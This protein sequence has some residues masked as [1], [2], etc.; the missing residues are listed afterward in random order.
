MSDPQA[1]ISP[2]KPGNA[3]NWKGFVAGSGA[4][5]VSGAVT[6]PVDLVKVRMQLSG[7]GASVP[8]F[9]PRI[10]NAN[11]SPSMLRAAETVVRTEGARALYKG[12]SASLLRQA[13]FIGTK[14]G[15]YDV[16]KGYCQT[17]SE[18]GA[19]GNLGF[20][21]KILCG[22]GAGAMGA[23]VGNPSDLVMV[24]MQADGRLPIEQRRNYKN[25]G[26]AMVRIVRHEGVGTL[27]R[28][29]GPTVQRA[30]IITASQLAIYD[31]VKEEFVSSG[32]FQDGPQLHVASS[33]V[34]A[35]V[36]S[37][38]SNPVDLL[39]TRLMNMRP[40]STG[41]LPY[42]GL[43]DCL[44]QTVKNEGVLALWKGLGPTLARQAP[45][46]IVRFMCV[47]QIKKVLDALTAVPDPSNA[48]ASPALL[49]KTVGVAST[50]SHQ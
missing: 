15:T 3:E 9:N 12:L 50:S 49:L 37:V 17:S 21:S 27:W 16:L 39:K 20:F 44:V 36:A 45:L 40:D 4:A 48:C 7:T 6:H 42:T 23:A 2:V 43:Y 47:E 22:F 8:G 1:R 46:N 14:F 38:T 5:I 13:T 18:S 34:A 24:R 11:Y 31:Q 32:L 35:G 30:M 10:L 26:E 28:G 41:V 25:V 29:C 33:V 19:P